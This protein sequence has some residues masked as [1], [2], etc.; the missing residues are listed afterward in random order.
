MKPVR[1][2]LIEAVR[3]TTLHRKA[4]SLCT[5]YYDGREPSSIYLEISTLAQEGRFD[6]QQL[7]QE[8]ERLMRQ[9]ANRR[10]G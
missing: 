9:V 8:F 1:V 7:K 3:G 6:E 10:N 5:Q 2:R 4:E